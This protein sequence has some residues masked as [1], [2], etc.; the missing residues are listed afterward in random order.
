M[1]FLLWLLYIAAQWWCRLLSNPIGDG[2]SSSRIKEHWWAASHKRIS[3]LLPI[4]ISFSSPVSRSALTLARFQLA[5][6]Q[7]SSPPSATVSRSSCSRLATETPIQK[8]ECQQ[9]S[10]NTRFILLDKSMK[11]SSSSEGLNQT[12]LA[13]VADETAAV[14]FQLWGDECNAFE[15]QQL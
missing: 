14:H 11:T 7:P 9:H 8:T 4:S 5:V 1:T 13:L 15:P 6:S 12:C 3:P 10:V 2:L